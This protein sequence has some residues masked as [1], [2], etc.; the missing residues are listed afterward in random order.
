MGEVVNRRVVADTSHLS[1]LFRIG[2]DVR[3][4]ALPT[5]RVCGSQGVLFAFKVQL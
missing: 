4:G 1:G 5:V 3:S 2:S